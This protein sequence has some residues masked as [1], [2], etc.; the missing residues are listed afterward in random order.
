MT[1]YVFMSLDD[2]GNW[3]IR[4]LPIFLLLLDAC[5]GLETEAFECGLVPISRGLLLWNEAHAVRTGWRGVSV[6]IWA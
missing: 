3:G 1:Y 6:P 4:P 5:R 2:V